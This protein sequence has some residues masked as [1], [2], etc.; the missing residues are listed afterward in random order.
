MVKPLKEEF[1][2]NEQELLA[3]RLQELNKEF[4]RQVNLQNKLEASLL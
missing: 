2:A 1:E 4:E 3:E